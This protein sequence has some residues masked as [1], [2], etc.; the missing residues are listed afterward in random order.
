M[1]SSK[2][3]DSQKIMILKEVEAGATAVVKRHHNGTTPA[4]TI[5]DHPHTVV[6]HRQRSPATPASAACAANGGAVQAAEGA[7]RGSLDGVAV[8]VFADTVGAAVAALGGLARP[9]QANSAPGF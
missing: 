1:R 2:F 4:P 8:G 9:C 6:P 3:T 7:R 5:R